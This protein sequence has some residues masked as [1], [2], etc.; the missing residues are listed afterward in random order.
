MAATLFNQIQEAEARIR[1]Q[2]AHT[3]LAFSSGLS[4]LTGARVYLKCEH[5][6]HTGSFKFRGASNKVLTLGSDAAKGVITASSGNHGQGVALA[7]KLAGIPVTVYAS[8]IA[9]PM[10][11]DAIRALGAQVVVLEDAPLAVELAAASEAKAQGVAF[12]SPY[13]DIDVVAGQGTIGL[14]IAEQAAAQGI[15]PSAVFASVGGGGLISGIGTALNELCPET[16][17]IGCWPKNSTHF[18]SSLLAGH[19][20]EV[21]EFDTVSDGTA[22]AMEPDS[23]TF[24]IGQR[25]I[26]N[27]AVVTEAEIKRAM[28]LVAETERWMIEGAAGVA[29]AS[30]IQQA[31]GYQGKDVVAVICGRNIGLKKFIDAVSVEH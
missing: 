18:Y 31:D 12:I 7:G 22:G 10:K 3:P 30:M 17:V 4:R 11:L 1:N 28:K 19:I 14:E 26:S 25:V 24:E 6:Q 13:N 16:A 27:T 23:I 2:V 29:V 20:V 9:S 21:E 5:L 8:S 15:S